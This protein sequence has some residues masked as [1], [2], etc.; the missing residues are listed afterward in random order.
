V[1]A[2]STEFFTGSVA[3]G[4]YDDGSGTPGT[5][6]VARAVAW[7]TGGLATAFTIGFV[8]MTSDG[9]AFSEAVILGSVTPTILLVLN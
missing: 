3:K 4:L 5:A 9:N 6:R 8:A 1:D 7:L 2:A